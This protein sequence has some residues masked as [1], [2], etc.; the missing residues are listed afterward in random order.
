MNIPIVIQNH[1]GENGAATVAM[2]LACYEKYVP[3]QRILEECPPSRNG[4]KPI[5]L[6]ETAQVFGMDAQM[7]RLNPE[8]LS[9]QKVPFVAQWKKRFFV[10]VKKIHGQK[11]TVVDAAKGEYTLTMDKFIY[12][13][14][15]TIIHMVPGKEF[16]AD[17]V[18]PTLW[19]LLKKRF[20]GYEKSIGITL[21]LSV[22]N[23]LTHMFMLT[24]TRRMLD[25]VMSGSVPEEYGPLLMLMMAVLIFSTLCSIGR[26]LFINHTSRQ[27]A[28]ASGSDL[29]K[30][31]FRLPLAFFEQH[32]AGELMERF[33][34]NIQLDHALLQ[35][36]FPRIIDGAMVV[37]YLFLMI[38]Y[39]RRLALI[40]TCIEVIYILLSMWLQEKR[41]IVSRSLIASSG[42][43]NASIL[44]GIGTIET[45]KT[46]GA[47]RT[48][49]SLWR[50]AQKNHE[51][52]RYTT[53]GLNTMSS[54]LT[55]VHSVFASAAV[56]IAGAYFIMEGEFTLGMLSAFQSVLNSIRTSVGNCISTI[57]SLQ[58][59][60][61]NM[62][63]VE[64]ILKQP[65]CEE[66][67]LDPNEEP[68]KLKGIVK[69]EHVSYRYAKGD[70]LAVDDVS[71]EV[72]PGQMVALVGETGCGKSTLLKLLADMYQPVSGAILYDGKMR[73]EI[74]DVIFHAS[75]ASVDQD[76]LVFEDSI[77]SNLKMWD[78]T[79]EDFEMILAA[80]DAQIHDRIVEDP[81]KYDGIIRENGKN[82][83][84]GE[85]QRMELARALAQE[86]T[87][88]LLDEFTSALDARTEE[89]VFQAIRNKGTSCIIV[90][91]RLS[92]IVECD[93]ILVLD[94]GKIIQQ[95][96]HNELYAAEGLYRNLVRMQ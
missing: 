76:T 49:F 32:S 69:V 43:L 46:V 1:S 59:K 21:V 55:T 6:C 74:A 8:E 17:G 91:H 88:L 56:L 60:R 89:K 35:R 23:T 39:D 63:R 41:M 96:T 18:K 57:N 87:V 94:K 16:V 84:G 13:Y 7:I 61:T 3:L 27:M 65:A 11:V 48:F 71:F 50:E 52:N 54:I 24:L 47:E 5:R 44:N 77:R 80:R 31:L 79:I 72:Q 67:W 82:F 64:D 51:D 30:R 92:T 9:K 86:P 62:E 4:T 95:G 45:I 70:P 93:H 12:W 34:N 20:L 14:T 90:A 33:E 66:R 58:T 38:S 22:L 40:C 68:D 85:L 2:M 15:G 28:A 73:N 75:V 29:F 83:S 37:I 42:R 25:N 36:F 19:N 78:Q 26:L 81:H 53:M 10:I